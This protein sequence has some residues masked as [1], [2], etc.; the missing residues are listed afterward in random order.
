MRVIWQNNRTLCP[1]RAQ[2]REKLREK[3]HLAA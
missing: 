1:A 2:R 3:L